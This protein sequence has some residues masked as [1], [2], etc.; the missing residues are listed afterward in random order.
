MSVSFALKSRKGL[1]FLPDMQWRSSLCRSISRM[2]AVGL[3]AL[4]ALSGA[5]SCSTTRTLAQ[6]ES[7]LARNIVRIDS[8]RTLAPKEIEP[9][10]IQ[11]PN[12]YLIF[13][14]NPFLNLY[15]WSGKDES[16]P[17]NKMLR[18]V[19]V[20]PVVFDQAE[21]ASSIDNIV[22]HLEYLGYYGSRV[23]SDIRTKGRKVE[24]TYSV[25]PGK[26][27]KIGRITFD[28]PEGEFREDFF[29]DTSS[30]TIKPGDFLSEDALEKE[31][32][33]SAASFRDLGYFGFTKNYYSFEAD[34][35]FSKDTADL[36]MSIRTY[37]RNQGPESARPLVKHRIGEVSITYDK[38]IGFKESVLRDLNTIHPGDLYNEEEVN[39]TYSRFSS[40]KLFS[41]VNIEMTPRDTNVVDC[42]I[43]LGR[44]KLQGFKLNLEGSSNSSGLVGISPQ[45]GYYHKNIF[46][47]GEWLDLGFL[48]NFQ[49]KANDRNVKSN[50][51]GVSLGV[52]FPKM[53]GFPNSLFHGPSV[54]R[55]EVNVS[56]NY[57]NRPEYTRN[58]ISTHFG[59]SGSLRQGRLRYQ[60][61]PLQA[62]IVRLY[63]LDESFYKTL[64]GNPFMRDA[65]QNHFDVGS[66]VN[67]YLTS[68]SE[69]SPKSDH[70]FIRL[71]LDASGNALSLFKRAMRED[72]YGSRLVW[73][74][75]YSQYVRSEL[76]LGKTLFF[77]RNGASSL[78]M[79]LLGGVGYAYGNS[80]A[81]PFEKQFYSGGA[82]S[83]RGWQARALGP[84]NSPKDSSFVIPSQTGDLKLEANLEYRFPLFWKLGGA[85]FT[86]VGNIW[87]LH[88][89]EDNEEGSPVG[90][91]GFLG[92]IAA[93]WGF[94]L[95]LDLNFLILRLDLGMRLHDPSLQTDRW[96]G[97][98]RWLGRDSFAVHFG[99][100]HPF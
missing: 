46:K 67:A 28:V 4:A 74:T 31:S 24:V 27:F 89:S 88:A 22:R 18:R 20:A 25:I 87:T 52:S 76:T 40:L 85:L 54:P 77:G 90:S 95:R 17:I 53:L 60:L 12:S 42:L 94:G 98:E 3:A 80:S 75:P 45:L 97:P 50:E 55:T 78:A 36:A 35:L 32:A 96:L 66:G 21:V 29:A 63:D 56:Y 73:G 23:E 14:W 65:Y 2:S 62:K 92:T 26:R 13:G 70:E 71:Q 15:N 33:R 82:N 49:F 69:I 11:K 51:F 16:R 37:T 43:D 5:L 34:T 59:Y 44:S 84:G 83:M 72:L 30:I 79:R 93:N 86:D 57:Q 81:L 39:T 8:D 100:G 47:G 41:G 1:L 61:H 7:R 38:D 9:Y 58:I 10:I 48:G 99:V 6:G 19:G 68:T 91:D 64:E